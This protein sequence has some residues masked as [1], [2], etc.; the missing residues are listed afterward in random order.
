MGLIDG[1]RILEHA[2]SW[3]WCSCRSSSTSPGAGP[4]IPIQHTVQV[5]LLTSRVFQSS[6]DDTVCIRVSVGCEQRVELSV[7]LFA[8]DQQCLALCA[9]KL[10]LRP[11]RPHSNVFGLLWFPAALVQEGKWRK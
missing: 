6:D 5:L 7:V 3:Q 9:M 2:C 8:H 4:L 1:S 10:L 11:V